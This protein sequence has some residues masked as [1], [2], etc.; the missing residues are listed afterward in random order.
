MIISLKLGDHMWFLSETQEIIYG[1]AE[2]LGF[3]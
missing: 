3:F 1:F 2:K